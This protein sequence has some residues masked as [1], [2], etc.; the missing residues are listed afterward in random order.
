M[1]TSKAWIKEITINDQTKIRFDADDIV[2]IVGPNNSGKSTLLRELL[3]STKGKNWVKSAKILRDIQIGQEGSEQD[4]VNSLLKN[5]TFKKSDSNGEIIYVGYLYNLYDSSARTSWRNTHINGLDKLHSFFVKF[6]TADSRL[7]IANSVSNIDFLNEAK[8]HPVHFLYESDS[9]EAKFSESFR[10]AFNS[11]LIVDRG[12]GKT[13]HL[14]VGQKPKPEQGEDRVS[15]GYL[16]KLRSLPTIQEQGDGMKSYVG[17]LLESLL[18]FDTIKLID[19][20]EVFLHPPQARFIGKMLAKEIPQDKQ[21]FIATHSEDFLKGVLESNSKRVKILRIQ[22]NN[23]INHIKELAKDQV[24]IIWSDP[25]LRHS[26]VLSGLFHTNVLL[27]EGDGDCRFFSAILNAMLDE[28][29]E[30]KEEERTIKSNPDPLFIHCGGKH[31]MPAVV[32]ALT[33]LDVPL[34]VVCDFDLINSIEPL[35]EIFEG[36]GGDWSEIEKDF[37]LIKGQVDSMKSELGTNVV[38]EKVG[39][40][41]SKV[42]TSTFPEASVL[43]IKEILKR[44]S[45]WSIA[46]SV[47]KAFIPS[48]DATKAYNRLI[49]KIN[50]KKL[51]IIE[52][53]EL[54][55]FAKSVGNHG[56]KWVNEVLTK[57]LQSDAELAP[58]RDFV[59]QIIK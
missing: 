17:L 32:N 29:S 57:N 18:G 51:F 48:G 8:Q 2:L 13:I 38:K 1:T 46:K 47:G 15:V 28:E 3:N 19:E 40:I 58:A 16:K 11:D 26:N 21:V 6:I 23:E 45:P 41:L 34:S 30:K 9:L 43:E 31:K 53:G 36:L 4:V 37:K 25:I 24:Q 10:K 49:E 52:I 55:K 33:Y 44:T 39:E 35:K 20:P 56:P 54:E 5:A 12:A 7:G 27:C 14:H 50:A 59:R 42:T 22:R